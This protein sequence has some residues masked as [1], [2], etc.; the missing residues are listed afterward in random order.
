MNTVEKVIYKNQSSELVAKESGG[1]IEL[2]QYYEGEV[3]G[4]VFIYHDEAKELVN[5][6]NELDQKD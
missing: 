1:V 3:I 5:F 6:I 2:I 4:T